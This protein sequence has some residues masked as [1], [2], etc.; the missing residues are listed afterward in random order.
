MKKLAMLA[1]LLL[2]LALCLPSYGVEEVSGDILVYKVSIAA[3][4]IV[5]DEDVAYI[6]GGTTKGYLVVKVDF[7]DAED[8]DPLDSALVL[9]GKDLGGFKRQVNMGDVINTYDQ[10]PMEK[11]GNW[12]VAV[13]VSSQLGYMVVIG[14]ATWRDIGFGKLEKRIVATSLTGHGIWR[15]DPIKGKGIPLMSSGTVKADLQSNWTKA[16]NEDGGT[17]F[18]DVVADIQNVKLADYER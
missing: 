16:Y 14:K 4:A 17:D 15:Y 1:M 13:N 8:P 11:V 12:A 10:D 6:G 3:K 5:I 7:T 9:Y 18:D 2:V